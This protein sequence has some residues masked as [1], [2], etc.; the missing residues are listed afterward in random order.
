MGTGVMRLLSFWV[1]VGAVGARVVG[2]ASASAAVRSMGVFCGMSTGVAVMRFL[3][4]FAFC[5]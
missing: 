5:R 3:F 4:P 1:D 2:V